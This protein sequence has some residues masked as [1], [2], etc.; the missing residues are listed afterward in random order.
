[1]WNLLGSL[2][3]PLFEGGKL[4]AQ[5]EIAKLN[6]EQSFWSYQDT[7]LNAVNEVE[8]ALGQE[9]SLTQQQQ[10]MD[11]AL[12]SAERSYDNYL[13]KYQQGLVDILDLLTVQQQ[14]YD[15]EAT[16]AQIHFSL[17]TNR[18]DLGLALGLGVAS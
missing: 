14:V 7:L 16:L 13:S 2:S 8:N 12:Q 15:L 3:A 5:V 18:I 4:R 17:L 6:A 9:H 1:L 10:Y 11:I